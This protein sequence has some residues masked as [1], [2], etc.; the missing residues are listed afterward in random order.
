MT[1]NYRKNT[2]NKQHQ[3]KQSIQEYIEPK[4]PEVIDVKPIKI[5][6][7]TLIRVKNNV[8]GELIYINSKTGEET[9]WTQHGEVQTMTLSDLRA[10]KANQ[11][12]FFENQWII[13][14]GTEDNNL[15]KP[16]DIYKML[17]VTRYYT[18]LI[19]PSNFNYLCSLSPE[20]IRTKVSLL[21]DGSKQNLIV[22]LN[23]Y[24]INGELDSV[25]K[26]RAFEDALGCELAELK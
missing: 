18:N 10:M 1:Q 13:I 14:L 21:S 25:K 17:G 19:D 5:D 26:I 7:S 24:I 15:I 11:I 8:F 23:E 6:E 4:T 22:A 16:A 2:T 9:K 3:L 20:E 12:S